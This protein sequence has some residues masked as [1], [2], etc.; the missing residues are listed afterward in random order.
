MLTIL[1][2]KKHLSSNWVY[3]PCIFHILVLFNKLENLMF[4]SYNLLH[5]FFIITKLLYSHPAVRDRAGLFP[6]H[7]AN[8][9]NSLIQQLCK[10]G[11]MD[12]LQFTFY[13][14]REIIKNPSSMNLMELKH[15]LMFR[16]LTNQ[17]VENCKVQIYPVIELILVLP[18]FTDKITGMKKLIVSQLHFITEKKKEEINRPP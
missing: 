15:Q 16:H 2:I 6:L 8:F 9:N 10:H 3:F 4:S 14:Y 7:W 13:Q 18:I 17:I 12:N 1:D 11:L 5:I